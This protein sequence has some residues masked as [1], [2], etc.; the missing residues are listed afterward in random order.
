[1]G[2]ISNITRVVDFYKNY[3]FKSTVTLEERKKLA[4]LMDMAPT[5]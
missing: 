2:K 4:S 3:G 5:T 1:M